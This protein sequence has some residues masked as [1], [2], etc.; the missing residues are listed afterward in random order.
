VR[1]QAAYLR[2]AALL[3]LDRAAEAAEALR[4]LCAKGARADER[5][6]SAGLLRGDAL[7][8]AGRAAEAADQLLWVEAAGPGEVIARATLLRLGEAMAAAQQWPASEAAYGRFLDRFAESEHAFRARFGLGWAR[9][10]QGQH[11]PAIEAYRAVTA[12]HQGATAAR[13][14]FQIGECLFAM[15][16]YEE[17]V[18]EFVKADA[19]YGLDEWS[20]AA[21]YEAGRCLEEMGRRDDARA[22]WTEVVD[23]FASSA[24]ARQS[25]ER[26]N[27]TAT[28]ALPGR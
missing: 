10:N 24:W 22:R 6:M 19:I 11:E 12:S 2:G 27:A 25:K 26:L 17:A 20:A 18:K 13:A 15:K 23:R 28:A 9:E 7:L 5:S 4:V 16:R 1:A 3:R 21:L 14:Q 8:H